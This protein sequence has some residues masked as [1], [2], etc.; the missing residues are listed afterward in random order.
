MKAKVRTNSE[1]IS[2]SLPAIAF[3]DRRR[4]IKNQTASTNSVESPYWRS[5]LGSRGLLTAN[6]RLFS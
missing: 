5:Y 6:Y 2:T 4:P 1:L 3:D